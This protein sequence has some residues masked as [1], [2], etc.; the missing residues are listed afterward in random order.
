MSTLY[1]TKVWASDKT[2]GSGDDDIYLTLFVGRP[3]PLKSFLVSVGPG[4]HWDSMESGDKRNWWIKL[5]ENYSVNNLHLVMMV[6][7]DFGKDIE[8]ADRK[9]VEAH[10]TT[11]YE[12]YNVLG[13]SHQELANK[14]LPK[15]KKEFDIHSTNDNRL[16][17]HFLDMG[18]QYSKQRKFIGHGGKY[19]VEFTVST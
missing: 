7:K 10:M 14:L 18:G 16:T 15:M 6:E 19:W 11:W 5:Y 8:G 4:D 2:S 9:L 13:A 12:S 3:S 1:A 17:T